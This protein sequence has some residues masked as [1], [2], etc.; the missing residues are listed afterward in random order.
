MPIN[1]R[2]ISTFFDSLTG[3]TDQWTVGSGSQGVFTINGSASENYRVYGTDPFGNTSVVWETR[4]DVTYGPDGGWNTDFFSIDNTQTYR[5]SVWI[6][7]T[8]SGSS[9]TYGRYYHGCTGDPSH[10]INIDDDTTNTNPYWFSGIYIDDLTQNL[11]YLLVGHVLPH[12]YNAGVTGYTVDL[13]PNSGR[14]TIASGKVGVPNVNTDFK[15]SPTT[16]SLRGRTYHFYAESTVPHLQFFDP[17][18]ELCDGS[19][20]TINE[21]LYGGVSTGNEVLLSSE[22]ITR[23]GASFKTQEVIATGGDWIEEFGNWRAHVFTGSGTFTLTSYVGSAIKADHLIVA[24]GGGGGGRRGGGGGAGGV[25]T[26][27]TYLTGNTYTITVGAGGGGGIGTGASYW[28]SNGGNST[29]NGLTAIG[30]GGG[31]GHIKSCEG[32]CLRYVIRPD[33]E[34]VF[35]LRCEW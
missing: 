10:V 2:D 31:G 3:G 14:Y 17:R 5:Y 28:G 19:E 12:D 24:G 33:S 21:L 4:P 29:F 25:L 32:V 13:H 34:K 6:K 27:Y 11:W 9:T 30:G 35:C 8:S 18:L 26:G 15:F 23:E 7:K 16:T 1:F 22:S 20:P